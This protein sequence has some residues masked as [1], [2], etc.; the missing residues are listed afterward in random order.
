MGNNKEP[1]NAQRVL[2]VEWKQLIQVSTILL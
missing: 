2:I 1:H